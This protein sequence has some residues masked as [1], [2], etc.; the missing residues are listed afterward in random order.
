M[1]K[2]KNMDK[3]TL[4]YLLYWVVVS[5]PVLA[6][7]NFAFYATILIVSAMAFLP[8]RIFVN[9]ME[10]DKYYDGLRKNQVIKTELKSTILCFIIFLGFCSIFNSVVKPELYKLSASIHNSSIKSSATEV[11]NLKNLKIYVDEKENKSYVFYKMN[12]SGSIEMVDEDNLISPENSEIKERFGEFHELENYKIAFATHKNQLY[13]EGLFQVSLGDNE[14]LV[15]AYIPQEN[16]LNL[17]ANTGFKE[18]LILNFNDGS[19]KNLYINRDSKEIA[20]S[21][22]NVV[23]TEKYAETPYDKEDYFSYRY[24]IFKSL[25]EDNTLIQNDIT[26]N[27]LNTYSG[28]SKDIK[29]VTFYAESNDSYTYNEVVEIIF[30]E[31]AYVFRTGIIDVGN[32][33]N[34]V[35]AE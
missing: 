18:A 9:R 15:K 16:A 22:N 1:Q 29:R 12:G 10:N 13:T 4:L 27:M 8:Y 7:K 33:D 26:I 23:I 24:D 11:L 32:L 35:C 34:I 20:I 28:I 5:I 14:Y 3:K 21:D 2:I 25:V 6:I 31:L 19:H 17:L 30:D